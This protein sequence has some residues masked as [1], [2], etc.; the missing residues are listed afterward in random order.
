MTL[1]GAFLTASV[2]GA[3]HTKIESYVFRGKI[4]L[5][6]SFFFF[7]TFEKNI[8]MKKIIRTL[9]LTTLILSSFCLQAQKTAILK[10]AEVKN[11]H[12]EYFQVSLQGQNENPI[13]GSFRD[14]SGSFYLYGEYLGAG[15]NNNIDNIYINELGSNR[16]F[17]VKFDSNYQAVWGYK[18]G[19]ESSISRL[20][21]MEGPDSLIYV[22]ATSYQNFQLGNFKVLK[23][24]TSG[25]KSTYMVRLN[26]ETGQPVD[27][28]VIPEN[29]VNYSFWLQDA[30][31]DKQGNLYIA[32]QS[33]KSAASKPD[34]IRFEHLAAPWRNKSKFSS[35]MA[36]IV[37]YDTE[38][39]P[40]WLHT[41]GA[42]TYVTTRLSFVNDDLI[43]CAS[44]RISHDDWRKLFFDDEL[45]I[46]VDQIS[47]YG[48]D[49]NS[50]LAKI[51]SGGS[52]DWIHP[53]IVNFTLDESP[54]VYVQDMQTDP[55]GNIYC[56]LS[57]ADLETKLDTT[58]FTPSVYTANKMAKFNPDG[59][60]EW[61]REPL[62][63]RSL[64]TYRK[65]YASYMNVDQYGNSYYSFLLPAD[66]QTFSIDSIF[67]SQ[68]FEWSNVY[69]GIL[70]L[71]TDGNA[72]DAYFN[73]IPENVDS[74]RYKY[75]F[76]FDNSFKFPCIDDEGTI[77]HPLCLRVYQD[78]FYVWDRD[79]FYMD[80]STTLN[81]YI[82][83]HYLIF[84]E[85]IPKAQ[86]IK[87]YKNPSCANGNDGYIHLK[88][89]GGPTGHY[90]NWSHSSSDLKLD[91]LNEGTYIV[92]L[93]DSSSQQTTIDTFILFSP[94]LL[95]GSVVIKDDTNNTSQGS[96]SVS[97]HGGIPPYSYQWNDP[98]NS[99]TATVSNLL[100][101]SYTVT[102]TDSNGCVWDTSVT[103][104]NYINS[105]EEQL[106]E[107]SVYPNPS[108]DGTL[109]IRMS[110]PKSESIEII[111][112]DAKGKECHH[113]VFSS[114]SKGINQ[115]LHV[116]LSKG[117]YIIK[118]MDGQEHYLRKL[119]VL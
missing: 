19:G 55:K 119:T 24:T 75:N 46:D 38:M 6:L 48:Q 73:P 9:L 80:Y 60:L 2:R 97:M 65:N 26:P 103:V 25:E 52:L 113:E 7:F 22:F 15:D 104:G 56:Y 86:L 96:V 39:N 30:V 62:L 35:C 77:Y 20:K 16:S 45:L 31:F 81:G 13:S 88:V 112:I 66:F 5:C 4:I 51:D 91:N 87:E 43:V 85:I 106:K 90:L 101:G 36:A 33:F 49:Y 98:Q 21:I 84:G 108:K 76:S 63:T 74:V 99:T 72:V 115:Q 89:L 54:G 28:Q 102:V 61:L 109:F 14:H 110:N 50:F 34:S 11:L 10:K 67:H 105:I 44:A 8:C 118:I 27:G 40:V 29:Y 57:M 93:Y 117:N 58:W 82:R 94:P 116:K 69:W 59:Y 78:S 83:T 92:S 53:W 37:K 32:L 114:T 12:Q 17:I 100:S 79:T 111:V 18:L 47:S 41:F 3:K 107:L 1:I 23:R 70:K 71:D 95:A 42:V 64:N 68:E